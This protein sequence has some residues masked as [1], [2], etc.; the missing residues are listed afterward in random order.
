M[1]SITKT[2]IGG[3]DFYYRQGTNDLGIVKKIYTENQYALPND[4]SGVTLL[5][6]GAQIGSASLLAAQRGARVLAFEPYKPSFEL[7]E[8]N[9]EGLGV[10]CYNFGLGIPGKRTLY[11]NLFNTGSNS[12]YNEWEDLK[13][14]PTVKVVVKSI[15]PFLDRDNIYIK[16]DCEGAEREILPEVFPHHER[17]K[18][19]FCEIHQDVEFWIHEIKKFYNVERRSDCEF[20]CVHT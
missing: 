18:M 20:K 6:I 5:D 2:T 16:M 4:L 1:S 19:I 11:H 12:L 17:I 10:T 8:K 9:V 7:L 15:L 13:N 3:R 14:A